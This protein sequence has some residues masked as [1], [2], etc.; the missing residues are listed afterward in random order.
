MPKPRPVKTIPL[1]PDTHLQEFRKRSHENRQNLEAKTD[2]LV[3]LPY[4][5]PVPVQR[6]SQS[7]FRVST[8]LNG[9]WCVPGNDCTGPVPITS[10]GFFTCEENCALSN[11]V[12]VAG[13]D[14]TLF[15][16]SCK[17]DSGGFDYRMML[18]EYEGFD[19]S[20]KAVIVGPDGAQDL[21]RCSDD[22]AHTQDQS[23]LASKKWRVPNE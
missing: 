8:F 10:E 15:D 22:R 19:G 9:S 1:G 7:E 20:R 14:A 3:E 4:V 2:N 16:V 18:K 17:G 5:S 21:E 23:G 13:F 11:P 6:S 12:P